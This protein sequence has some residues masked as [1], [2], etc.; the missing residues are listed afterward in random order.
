MNKNTT[1]IYEDDLH[2]YVDNQLSAEKAKEVEALIRENPEIA[3]QVQQWQQ[4]NSAL[5]EHF[6][7]NSDKAIPK[8]LTLE[9]LTL[10]SPNKIE[11][12]KQRWYYAIAASLLMLISGSV[13]WFANEAQHYK[14]PYSNSFASSAI[15]A[16]QVFSVENIHPVEVEANKQ[17]HLVSWLSKRIDHPIEIPTLQK[18]G[19]QLLGGRLLPMK[20]G[21]TAA[22]FMFENK[23]GERIT[24]LVSKNPSYKNKDLLSHKENTVNSFYWMN[25]N[26]A[27]SVTGEI[28]H[29]DLHRLSLE[30]YKQ[31]KDQQ[32]S[33][34]TSL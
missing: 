4:Q 16:H 30:I 12:K 6:I 14:K 9:K 31:T 8:R 11:P 7:M 32:T 33:Q 5:K 3:L 15:S 19:Y 23:E 24:W 34:L 22:Q 1:E 2:G 21:K 20:K 17:N 18:Y 27:Y 29:K 26:I 28:N 13:G 10:N 25:S